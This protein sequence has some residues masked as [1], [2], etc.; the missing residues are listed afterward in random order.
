M[1]HLLSD[2]T[3]DGGQW[4]MIL[5]LINKYGV[6]PKKC[7]VESFSSEA[8][9]K[10]NSILKSTVSIINDLLKIIYLLVRF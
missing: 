9:Q 7:F 2:P 10:L 3:N 1:A 8:S 5:N 6:I 4:D